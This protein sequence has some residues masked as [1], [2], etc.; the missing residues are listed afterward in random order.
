MKNLFLGFL[1]YSSFLLISCGDNDDCVPADF[2]ATWT[3]QSD[4]DCISDSNTSI[5]VDNSFTIIAGSTSTS[6]INNGLDLEVNGCTASLAGFFDLELDGDNLT[7]N[8]NGCSFDYS[9]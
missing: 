1:L 9:R 5:T 7:A 6:V 8:I 2:I 3:L 4:P